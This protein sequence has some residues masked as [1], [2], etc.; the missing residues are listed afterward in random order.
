VGGGFDFRISGHV[1]IRPVQAEYFM[2][3]LPNGLDDREN[4]L[5]LGAGIVLR[6][7]RN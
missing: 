6:L 2:T 5:R 1:S 7:G 3:R 4:N